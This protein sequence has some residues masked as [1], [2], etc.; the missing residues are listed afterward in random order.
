VRNHIQRVLAKLGAHNRLEAVVQGA[1]YHL[2]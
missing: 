1:R 2:I